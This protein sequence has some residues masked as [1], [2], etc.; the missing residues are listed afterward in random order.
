MTCVRLAAV[1]DIHVGQDT[2]EV[3]ASELLAETADVLL[4]AGDLTRHGTAAR[5]RCSP[6]SW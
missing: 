5:P 6:P 1:G 2:G 3:L 4:I